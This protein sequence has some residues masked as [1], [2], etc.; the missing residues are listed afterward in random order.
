MEG[1]FVSLET[2]VVV[3]EEYH[4]YQWGMNW[5]HKIFDAVDELSYKPMSL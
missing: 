3:T 1:Y 4:G 2:S 5:Y